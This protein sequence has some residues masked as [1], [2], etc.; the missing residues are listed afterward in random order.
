MTF[1]YKLFFFCIL[2]FCD[3]PHILHLNVVLYYFR[4]LRSSCPLSF[5]STVFI[6][7]AAVV[8]VILIFYNCNSF[9]QQKQHKQ[10]SSSFASC[11]SLLKE[12]LKNIYLI[13]A[14]VWLVGWLLF[15]FVLFRFI[16]HCLFMSRSRP[17]EPIRL[18]VYNTQLRR[19]VYFK[20][21]TLF[22]FAL[23]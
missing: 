7:V 21:D 11:V 17:Y 9:V 2:I 20:S 13:V 18:K 10:A 3:F 23:G 22:L 16:S 8:N 19:E 14:L 1:A 4:F 15:Y 6:V 12:V 5:P